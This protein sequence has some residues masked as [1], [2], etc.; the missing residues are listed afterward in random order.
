MK[1]NETPLCR[2]ALLGISIS[3]LTMTA[4]ATERF[5]TYSYEPETMPKSV[6]EV[7]Q[8]FTLR[9]G[10]N[11]RVGQKDYNRW[12]FRT[13]LEHGVTDNYTASLYVNESYTNFRDPAT[14]RHTHDLCWDGISIENRYMV[15]NPATKPVGLALA[16]IAEVLGVRSAEA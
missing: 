9:E 14:G 8:W 3:A 13:E 2:A 15:L 12:E 6:W 5:F 11:G 10:R 4:S 16:L 7:E 1:M